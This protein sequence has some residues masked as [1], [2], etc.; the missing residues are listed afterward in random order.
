MQI[1]KLHIAQGTI[2]HLLYL[3]LH[4][5]LYIQQNTYTRETHCNRA[6]TSTKATQSQFKHNK[7]MLC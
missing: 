3:Q 1:R 4:A 7:K 5:A 2:E 6:T